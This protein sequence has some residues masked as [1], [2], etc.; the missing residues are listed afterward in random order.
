[1]SELCEI[2]GG[3]LV[4]QW[5]RNGKSLW[6]GIVGAAV[7]SFMAWCRRC[8][9]LILDESMLPTKECS[10]RFRSYGGGRW[11]GCLQTDST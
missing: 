9:Q 3:Y 7:L 2:G 10:S 6:V 5:L 8:S 4:W 11:I 1:M